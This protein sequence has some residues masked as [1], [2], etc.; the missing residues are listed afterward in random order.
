MSP[1]SPPSLSAVAGYSFSLSGGPHQVEEQSSARSG[2]SGH[3]AVDEE[4][5]V[6]REP[7][8][9]VSPPSMAEP[10][11]HGRGLIPP[12]IVTPSSLA[13]RSVRSSAMSPRIVHSP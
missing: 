5:K 2:I 1:P 3:Y 4:S 6:E 11:C 12:Q 10:G 8:A 9:A 7:A 13:A